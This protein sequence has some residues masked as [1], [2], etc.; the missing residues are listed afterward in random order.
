[1]E[2]PHNLIWHAA[3][4][5]MLSAALATLAA[6]D[7]RHN[8]LPDATTVPMLVLGLLVNIVLSAYAAFADAVVSCVADYASIRLIHEFEVLM[9]G[10]SAIGL[11]DA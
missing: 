2:L 4:L 6:I 8:L 3:S 11:G 5:F 10:S 9:K 1:M 7:H